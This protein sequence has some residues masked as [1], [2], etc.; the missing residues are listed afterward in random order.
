MSKR[1]KCGAGL[2]RITGG[3]TYF[4]KLKKP[5]TVCVSKSCPYPRPKVNLQFK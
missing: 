3:G 5:V 4:R 2:H 1:C